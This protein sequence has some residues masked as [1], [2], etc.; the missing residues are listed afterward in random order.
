VSP[1]NGTATSVADTL[2]VVSLKRSESGKPPAT[3][4][5]VPPTTKTASWVKPRASAVAVALW[6]KAGIAVLRRDP[7]KN[8]EE[9]TQALFSKK[10]CW[11]AIAG[12]A[13]CRD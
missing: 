11:D 8:S 2:L 1:V 5:A 6:M 7:E 4:V 9:G 13:D 3:L 10:G 12:L